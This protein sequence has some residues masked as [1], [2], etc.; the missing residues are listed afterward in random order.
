MKT[1]LVLFVCLFLIPAT[2]SFGQT[3]GCPVNDYNCQLGRALRAFQDNPDDPENTYNI[4]MVY[5]RAGDHV[6]AINVFTM[7]VSSKGLKPEYAADG[8]NNRG[9]SQRALKQFDLAISDYSKAIEL[10]PKNAR[11]YVNRGNVSNDLDKSDD[12][13][14]DYKRAIAVDPSFALAFT[15]RGNLYVR[16]KRFDEAI[17]DLTRAI[18]LDP[19]NA[20]SFYTRA[21][22]YR[23]KNQFEKAIPDLDKYIELNP[24]NNRYLA[25]GY[26]NRGI[27]YSYLNDQQ[28]ALKDMTKAIEL[29]PDY[30][31]AYGARAVIYRKLKMD[32]L[33]AVDEQ[34]FK[35]LSPRS[36]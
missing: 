7:Y 22:A 19:L 36:N 6:R 2:N 25:D 33:A 15:N 21:M 29:A 26:L 24:G 12:A 13:L 9:I 35:A 23:A 16:I 11:Y 8:Y 30:A 18:E 32:D 28:R 20:E 3:F 5:Q 14:A 1:L 4:G 10:F 31:D 17:T 27:A 34:K